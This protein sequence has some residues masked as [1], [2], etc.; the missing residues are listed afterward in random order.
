MNRDLLKRLDKAA[1]QVE[2]HRW[3]SE[4]QGYDPRPARNLNVLAFHAGA[5]Q[6]H[7]SLAEALVRALN[8]ARSSDL[9]DALRD[10]VPDLQLRQQRAM[11]GLLRS[12]GV[13]PDAADEDVVEA[14]L[15]RLHQA[16]P[17]NRRDRLLT[18][19]VIIDPPDYGPDEEHPSP[20]T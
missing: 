4:P 9:H 11:W 14:T 2:T 6:S 7:E 20:R 16:V 1:R 17:L 13:D 3:Q 12:H 15:N 5:F 8:Y 19:R 10:D 18:V